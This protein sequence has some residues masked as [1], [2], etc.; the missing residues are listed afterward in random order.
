LAIYSAGRGP[1]GGQF[2]AQ[3]GLKRGSKG[4]NLGLPWGPLL[5]GPNRGSSLRACILAIYS[6]G[7]G[8]KGAQKGL[9]R[10]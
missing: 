2:R 1:K 7:R 8:P 9:K 3:K 6:A 5:R 10:G 4:A